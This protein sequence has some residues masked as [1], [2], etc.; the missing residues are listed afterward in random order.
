MSGNGC[1]LCNESKGE[2]K[3]AIY[4]DDNNIVYNRQ[5]KFDRCMNKR[6]L[7]FDFY[8]PDYNICIEYDGRHHYESIDYWGGDVKLKYTKN[9]DE[10]KNNY[11]KKYNIPIL[12]IPYTMSIEEIKNVIYEY[13]LS[14]T[15]AGCA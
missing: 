13:Y 3:I 2:N 6:K 1:P 8:L 11:C 9:N 15:T 5:H 4:L 12:R 7:P 14:V 10:I